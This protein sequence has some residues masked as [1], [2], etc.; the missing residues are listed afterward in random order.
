MIKE[1]KYKGKIIAIIYRKKEKETSINF[2]TDE[3]NNFQIASLNHKK[4]HIIPAH[5][6][7]PIKRNIIGTDEMLYVEEGKMKVLFYSKD[8]KKIG[9]EI[10][11]KGDLVNLIHEYHGFEFLKK[12]RIIY[13]KQGPYQNKQTDKKILK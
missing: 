9:E 13:V 4:G 11:E 5:I 1:I 3:T 12:S 2:L 10:L 8:K 6:H 7:K